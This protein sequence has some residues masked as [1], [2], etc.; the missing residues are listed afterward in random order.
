MA[1]FMVTERSDAPRPAAVITSPAEPVIPTSGHKVVF[2]GTAR[3]CA[4]HLPIVL[5][6]IERLSALFSNSAFVFVENDSADATRQLLVQWGA[7]RPR[8]WYFDL[9]GLGQVPVRTLRLEYAR[10][11]YL[12]FIRAD[13]VFADF[14]TLCILDMDEIGAHPVSVG[15]FRSAVDFLHRTPNCAGVFANRLGLYYD[16]WALR[17]PRLCPGDVW[18]EVLEW[19]QRYATSDEEAFAQTFAK[20]VV[21][22]SPGSPP[23]E[24]DSAFGGLGI[25]DLDRVRRAPNPYLGSRVHVLRRRDGTLVQFRMQQCEHVHFHAGLRQRGGRLFILPDLINGITSVSGKVPASA[26]RNLCF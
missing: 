6:N 23:V 7:G 21:V 4:A 20:R 13:S 24:V 3:D 15:A 25:Y 16:L 5:A 22:F 2:A 1:L 14:D 18:Y 12:E 10:N 11:V 19:A 17:E 26:Y 8:F 9:S